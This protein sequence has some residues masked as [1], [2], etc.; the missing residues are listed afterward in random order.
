M[1]HS[2]KVSSISI[3]TPPEKIPGVYEQGTA[4]VKIHGQI[5]SALVDFILRNSDINP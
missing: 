1:R 4:V 2:L 3:T 5:Y